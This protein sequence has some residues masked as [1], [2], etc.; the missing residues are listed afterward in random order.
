MG[1]NITYEIMEEED[2]EDSNEVLESFG[3]NTTDY[4]Q[5]IS[6]ALG[7]MVS[8][9]VGNLP[10]YTSSEMPVIRKRP[11]LRTFRHT[12]LYKEI[13]QLSGLPPTN[14]RPNEKWSLQRGLLKRENGLASRTSG[15]FTPSQHRM[16]SNLFVPNHKETRLMS[17]DS[18]VFICKFNKDGSR[19]ITASQDAMIRVFDSS[20]GTYHR[21]NRIKAQDVGWGILDIDFSPCGQYFTYSTWSEY[22]FVVPLNGT[23]DVFQWLRL[24]TE[25]NRSGIFSVRF[26]PGGETL[27]GGCNDSCIYMC[28]RETT[29][30]K[31]I[32]TE[33]ENYVDINAVSYVSD[34]SPDIFVSGCNLGVIK[35][36]DARCLGPSDAVATPVSSFLGH[37]DGITYI[38]PRNDGN[39]LLSNSK[40]Q[41]IKI[42]DLRKPTPVDKVCNEKD[43]PMLDWD[44]RWDEVPHEYYNPTKIM[45]GDVSVMTFRGHRVTKSLIRAKFSPA[46][47][48]GQRYIYTG[49]G[50]GRIIIYDVL[51]GQIKEAIEGHKDIVRDLSWHP[52]R[53]EIVSSSWDS[54]VNFNNF[55]TNS[56]N[57]SRSDSARYKAGPLRRSRRIAT[58]NG[59]YHEDDEYDEEDINFTW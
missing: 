25:V 27:I 12:P 57:R 19:L 35:L 11:D 40:D 49:C 54:H 14:R 13:K 15:Y 31:S 10:R 23:T 26:S 46:A 1:N 3:S 44:Y 52:V 16:I 33:S 4:R 29:A 28:N 20:K 37:Y 6:Y 48:T 42:W 55:K 2:L 34:M 53:S 51:T 7:R 50:T 56:N 47:Q 24:N 21:I 38:D 58:Q 9:I 17:F 59:E 41:S 30:V 32:K 18:K 5:H 8:H 43:L 36:W 45:D 39:Y 22:F